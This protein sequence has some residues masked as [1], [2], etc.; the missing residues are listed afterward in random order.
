MCGREEC[1]IECDEQNIGKHVPVS[2]GSTSNGA[3][4]VRV[5]D[6]DADCGGG[7]I[8]E[9]G[10]RRGVGGSG[11]VVAEGLPILEQGDCCKK[12]N[13]IVVVMRAVKQRG[14]V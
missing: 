5:G 6:G 4:T 3:M 11:G 13:W 1:E 10:G 12:S 8:G 2:W 7:P 9:S 14:R